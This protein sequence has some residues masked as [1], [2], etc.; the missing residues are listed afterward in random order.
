MFST[1]EETGTLSLISLQIFLPVFHLS[2]DFGIFAAKEFYA[3]QNQIN[4]SLHGLWNWYRA[5]LLRD[6]KRIAFMFPPHAFVVL[7]LHL[8]L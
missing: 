6:Y 2:F 3:F 8:N 7:F 4:I 5:F 1:A